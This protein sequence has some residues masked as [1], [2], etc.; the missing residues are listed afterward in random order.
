MG[1]FHLLIALFAATAQTCAFA[2][3]TD[4][5]DHAFG[6]HGVVKIGN[7]SEKLWAAGSVIQ[8]D[9]RI[10]V[11]SSLSDNAFA[12]SIRLFGLRPNGELDNHFGDNGVVKTK[13]GVNCEPG[14]IALMPDG[15]ILIAGW[16]HVTDTIEGITLV[17]YDRNG[18]LD[19]S[20]AND[21]VL[22]FPSEYWGSRIGAMAIQP[23]GKILIGGATIGNIPLPYVRSL[24]RSFLTRINSTGTFDSGFGV[25]GT[26]GVET[27]A[28][29][30]AVQGD[31]KIV[32][33]SALK[34]SSNTVVVVERYNPDSS[35]DKTFGTNGRVTVP[36][37]L[38][39]PSM[40]A[41]SILPTGKLIM[42]VGSQMVTRDHTLTSIRLEQD[43]SLDSNFGRNG[44]VATKTRFWH[45]TNL[46]A[47]IQDDGTSWVTGL[48]VRDKVPNQSQP[49]YFFS[50]GVTHFLSN[51][52]SDAS[53]GREGMQV[54]PIGI[55]TD[56]PVSV[57]V[58]VQ[59]NGDPVIVGH[60]ADQIGQQL[61]VFRL[62]QSLVHNQ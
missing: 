10:I 62:L 40:S 51:G 2:N 12:H 53:F 28:G 11:A 6:S 37:E 48:Y 25:N 22:I 36:L 4:R 59:E 18:R 38:D 34:S 15:R 39:R 41:L 55:L 24:P 49:P 61:V 7:V 47:A 3:E 58:S 1:L 26:I 50:F 17:M 9:G 32:T 13:V 30:L 33:T 54:V 29:S 21:G 23:D 31:G 60:S 16:A 42:L 52:Q 57:S 46:H 20:F 19:S 45:Y 56:Y 8:P 44:V 27:S 14:K 5:L 35:P 43:G